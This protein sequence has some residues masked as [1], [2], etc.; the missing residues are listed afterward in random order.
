M[1]FLLR[2]VPPGDSS[3]VELVQSCLWSAGTTGISE[4]ATGELLAGFE[5]E[6]SAHQ[7]SL[8]V[9]S[10]DL[11][12][13]WT[14]TVERA[15]ST[16]WEPY[17]KVTSIDVPTANG[18]EVEIEAS[19]VFGHGEHPTTKLMIDMLA[20]TVR[21]GARVLDVGTGSGV[22][23]VIAATNGAVVQAIDIDEQAV[24]VARLN[25]RRNG[26]DI[27]CSTTP[28][29]DIAVDSPGRFDVVVANVLA[30]VHAELHR[31]ILKSVAV[32][33]TVLLA[34]FLDDQEAMIRELYEPFE[35]VERSQ[36]F[37]WV[38]L[39]VVPTC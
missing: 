2:L 5:S 36:I 29:G 4:L 26:V 9:F 15:D 28:M 37:D 39:A 3:N 17:K 31:D 1:A 24:T 19:Q 13:R 25:A 33:G 21:K 14:V 34:G 6:K 20:E 22:L 12:G 30:P 35:L 16:S 7:A 18:T 11:N 23:G 8:E 10:I 32:G 38:G 27:E